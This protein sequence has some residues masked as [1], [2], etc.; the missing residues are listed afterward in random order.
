MK[1]E[2]H[3]KLLLDD[4]GRAIL[5]VIIYPRR[6]G[7][8]F[9][10]PH[11][12]QLHSKNPFVIIVHFHSRPVEGISY[13]AFCY[14]FS[15]SQRNHKIAKPTRKFSPTTSNFPHSQSF[16]RHSLYLYGIHYCHLL[17]GRPMIVKLQGDNLVTA[18]LTGPGMV[19][20]QS[21]PFQRL[22]QRIAR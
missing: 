14:I 17:R 3:T 15:I 9:K 1:Y 2:T 12:T 22:S 18:T 21:L 16:T 11:S 19:F 13:S 6:K 5:F 4:D 8:S 20:I 10:S 7:Q